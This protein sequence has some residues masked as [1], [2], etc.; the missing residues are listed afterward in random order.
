MISAELI[1]RYTSEVDVDF[2][3]VFRLE[4]PNAASRYIIDGTTYPQQYEVNVNGALQ[5]FE[6]VPTQITPPSR[7]DSGKA[8]MAISWCGIQG[9]ALAFLEEAFAAKSVVLKPDPIKLF[10]SEIIIGSPEPQ[11]TPWYEFTLSNVGVTESVV[12]ATATRAD[13]LNRTFPAERYRVNRFPG[14]LRR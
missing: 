13:I 8:D 4:H 10:Y 7:D 9:E 12:T 14:L 11:I 6:P 2:V 5:L 1:A 3:G